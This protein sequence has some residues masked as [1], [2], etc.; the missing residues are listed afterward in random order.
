VLRSAAKMIEY[1][2]FSAVA[3]H[4][5]KPR[6]FQPALADSR[7]AAGTRVRRANK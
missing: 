3:P 1:T 2:S 5:G 7:D 4:V 6:E